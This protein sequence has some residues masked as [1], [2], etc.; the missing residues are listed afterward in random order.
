[1]ATFCRRHKPATCHRA[2]I[3]RSSRR[4]RGTP[5]RFALEDQLD[6]PAEQRRRAASWTKVGSLRH[7][8]Q[9]AWSSTAPG[10]SAVKAARANVLQRL[11]GCRGSL[12]LNQEMSSNVRRGM[13][14]GARVQRG[15]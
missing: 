5:E 9:V 1:M 2:V 4:F 8:S 6:L 13:A 7:P 15:R 11:L 3:E 12:V 14:A 10:S